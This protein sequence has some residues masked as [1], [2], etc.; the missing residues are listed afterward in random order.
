MGDYVRVTKVFTDAAATGYLR[1][2]WVILNSMLY[3]KVMERHQ[4]GQP[5]SIVMESCYIMALPKD[6]E[7]MEATS[8]PSYPFPNVNTASLDNRVVDMLDG[9]VPAGRGVGRPA[10]VT[11]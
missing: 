7:G 10:K 6:A 9:E 5:K 2:G 11:V 4:N 8:I 1:D 3:E